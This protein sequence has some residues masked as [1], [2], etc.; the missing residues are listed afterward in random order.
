MAVPEG[1]G[2]A[3]VQSNHRGE[4][5]AVAALGNFP[6]SAQSGRVTT[7][8]AAAGVLIMWRLSGVARI[9]LGLVIVA[10]FASSEALAARVKLRNWQQIESARFGFMIAYP[11][12]VFELKA[13]Q[14]EEGQV[15][16]SHDGA[17]RL[18]VGAF[19]N[20]G[21]ATLAE[22]REQILSENYKGANLDFAPVKGTWF[23]VSGTQGTMHFYE[24]VSFT[25]GGRLINSWA[26]L[27]PVAE[28]PF[29]D[30]VVEAIARSYT[31]GAGRTGSC[32]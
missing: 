13:S 10:L 6:C 9:T 19:D 21:H 17:A 15:L 26:L 5:P 27:Y 24:R 2:V 20:D 3:A 22:Y 28:R 23:I 18:L 1:D 7:I 30:R 14:S 8:V 31:P 12:N 4:L 16:V 32:D 25:C 29:Y 11:G